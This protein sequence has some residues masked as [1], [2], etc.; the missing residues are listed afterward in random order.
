MTP[1]AIMGAALAC[2]AAGAA[3]LIVVDHA[4][5]RVA[6]VVLLAAFIG[7]GTLAV[8]N[9]DDLGGPGSDG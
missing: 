1:R 9:P 3:L 5:A 8:A 4:V 7:L 2:L 6:G